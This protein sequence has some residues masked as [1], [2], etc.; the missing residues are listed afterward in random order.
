MK[1]NDNIL[2]NGKIL[3]CRQLGLLI[4]AKRKQDGLTQQELAALAFVGVRFVSELENGKTSIELGK[5]LQVLEQ[6]GLELHILLRRIG[7][8]THG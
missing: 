4:K 6:L 2:P 7:R 3:D 5:T 1:S 8:I